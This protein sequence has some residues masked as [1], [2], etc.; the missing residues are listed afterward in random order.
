MVEKLRKMK[1]EAAKFVQKGKF[2]KALHAYEEILSIDGNDV[3]AQLKCGDIL[4][5]L[6]RG[7]EAIACYE[8]VAHIYASDG[9]LLKAIAACKL[10]L[11][12]DAEHNHTQKMLADLYAKKTG[13]A[14]SAAPSSTAAAAL[15]KAKAK[16]SDPEAISDEDIVLEEVGGDTDELP[17]IPL[18][19]DLSKNA[20]I[21]LMEQMTMRSALPG[22]VLISEGAVEDAMFIISSGKVK[23]TKQTAAGKEML[24]AHLS[25]GTFF[26]EI[27]LLSDSPRTASVIAVEETLLFVVSRDILADVVKNFPSVSNILM[28]FYKQR[29]LNNLMATSPIFQPL[30]ADARRGLIEKFKSRGVRA[31]E[32]IL[33]E[34]DKGDGL[35]VMLMGKAEVAKQVDGKRK[36]LAHLGAGDVFGEASLLSNQPVGASIKTLRKSLVLK[37]PKRVFSEIS[38]THPQLLAHISDLATEREKTNKAILE[39]TLRFSSEEGLVVV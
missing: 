27:A 2:D 14:K 9:L 32:K 34:G 38:A 3:T 20:F 31:N 19:S 36:V 23:V 7:Q 12:I 4:R 1:D 11:E 15:A 5:K 6:D 18:F 8:R 13:R 21:L 29:L 35:Y 25:D 30:D 17:T 16:S 39:G 10:I 26:G 33:V 37:L 28:R 22:E 24:L